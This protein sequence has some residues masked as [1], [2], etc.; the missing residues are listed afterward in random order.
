MANKGGRPQDDV[1][2][3]RMAK[4]WPGVFHVIR[5]P[6]SKQAYLLLQQA[7]WNQGLGVGSL[8]LNAALSPDAS[9]I[10]IKPII[11]F[12]A[13]SGPVYCLDST[14]RLLISA[15]LVLVSN[16]FLNPKVTWAFSIPT[17]DHFARPETNSLAVSIQ[18]SLDE[19]TDYVHCVTVW[20]NG[21]E[22]ASAAE[23]GTV[24]IWVTLLVFQYLHPMC[25]RP[26]FGKWLSCVVIDKSADWLVCG[27]G[28]HLCMWHLR[29]LNPTSVFHTPTTHNTVC[30][31]DDSLI[32]GGSDPCVYHWLVN[33]EKK[34]QVPC[35]ST[36]V[37]NISFNEKSE[38]T[39]VLCISGNTNKIDVC[40]NFGYKAFSLSIY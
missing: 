29:T 16:R 33:G 39:K 12:K 37:F 14:E 13:H 30:F 21:T 10:S 3:Q 31:Q 28:P 32:S 23:D 25:A 24:R 27:G 5:C 9:E 1:W 20:N 2:E 4:G 7:A 35:S 40:T 15:L 22:C 17:V 6:K 11:I 34:A 19:H 18:R 8:C 38:D 26:Q 36:N